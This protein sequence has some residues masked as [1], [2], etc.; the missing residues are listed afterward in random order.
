[1][2]CRRSPY[3]VSYGA[4]VAVLLALQA[5]AVMFVWAWN[6][7]CIRVSTVVIGALIGGAG[8][9]LVAASHTDESF[10]EVA[11]S[12]AA[13]QHD[14]VNVFLEVGVSACVVALAMMTRSY[15][16]IADRIL[17]SPAREDAGRVRTRGG[18]VD[19]FS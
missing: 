4:P 9:A 17:Q 19:G 7:S 3:R 14:P 10:G 1:M 5:S 11:G 12:I 16:I 15:R 8:F 2:R 13:G 6:Q 18:L